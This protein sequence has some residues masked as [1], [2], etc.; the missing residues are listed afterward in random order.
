MRKRCPNQSRRHCRRRYD[1]V[2]CL[3]SSRMVADVLLPEHT[4]ETPLAAHVELI[5]AAAIGEGGRPCFRAI[6][7]NGDNQGAI[8]VDLG[9]YADA[10][11]AKQWI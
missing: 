11:C 5:Y 8:H 1:A 2:A 7:Q 6:K 3:M 4:Q 9:S 10:V